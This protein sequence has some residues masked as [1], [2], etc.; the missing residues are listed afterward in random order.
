[1]QC[2]IILKKMERGYVPLNDLAMRFARFG[3]DDAF[4]RHNGLIS[5]YQKF[6]LLDMGFD[7]EVRE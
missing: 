1:M 4:H 7:V 5:E 3:N 6:E 2:R